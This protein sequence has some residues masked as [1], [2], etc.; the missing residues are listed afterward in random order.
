MATRR[1]GGRAARRAIR[2][3]APEASAPFLER[4]LL[5]VEVLDEEALVRIED[6]AEIILSEIGI[7]FQDFPDALELWRSVGAEI[8]GDLVKVPKGNRRKS[9]WSRDVANKK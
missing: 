1:G 6:N 4:K 7:A 8:E 2:T 5:P 3:A 9:S